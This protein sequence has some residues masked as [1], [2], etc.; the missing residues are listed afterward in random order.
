MRVPKFICGAIF[1]IALEIT[2]LIIAVI[3]GAKRHDGN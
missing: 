2:L 3:K 1:T